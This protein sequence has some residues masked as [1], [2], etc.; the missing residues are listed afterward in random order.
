M[1]LHQLDL[2][3]KDVVAVRDSVS[4]AEAFDAIR[5]AKVN[6]LAIVNANGQ[7]QGNLSASD[8]AN[9]TIDTFNTLP[10]TKLSSVVSTQPVIC[11]T[12]D[13]SFYEALKLLNETRLHRIYVVNNSNV[14]IGVV[15]LTDVIKVFK[16]YYL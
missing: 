4:V 2:T 9:E 11:A 1:T 14:P 13:T 3:Q 6:G 5:S 8:F 10:H 7:L 16:D 15:T 12:K